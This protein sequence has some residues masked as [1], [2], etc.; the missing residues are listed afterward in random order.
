MKRLFFSLL[1][2]ILFA[3][4]LTA[5]PRFDIDEQLKVL[6]SELELSDQ[7]CDSIKVVLEDTKEKMIEMRDDAGED[8]RAMRG[9]MREIIENSQKRIKQYL[10]DEQKD[11]YDKY[12]EQ[13]RDSMRK[14][15][16]GRN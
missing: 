3:G 2:I 16:R 1:A 10:N 12:L 7:Q 5:Q 4:G 6:K 15:S 14:R 13:R 11:L 9:H 8:R